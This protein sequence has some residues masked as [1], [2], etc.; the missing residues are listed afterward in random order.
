MPLSS[1][2]CRGGVGDSP[3]SETPRG[4]RL[5]PPSWTPPPLSGLRDGEGGGA[6]V[7]G[8][9]RAQP[10]WRAVLL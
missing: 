3:V 10:K 9:R 5:M 1:V 4:K 8:E 6:G 2:V 7:V